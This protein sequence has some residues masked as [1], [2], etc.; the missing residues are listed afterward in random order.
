MQLVQLTLYEVFGYAFP[1]AAGA[2]GI[3]LLYWRFFLP[4]DQDWT[5]LSSGGWVVI[6]AVAY[7]FGHFLQAVSNIFLRKRAWRPEYRTFYNNSHLPEVFRPVL[8]KKACQAI[9]LKSEERL[10]PEVIYDITDHEVLQRAKTEARDIYVYREGFYR[11][12]TLGLLFLGVGSFFRT[13]G[14]RA[15]LAVFGAHLALAPSALL[16]TGTIALAMAVFSFF[17]YVRFA[18]YRVKYAFYTFLIRGGD[19]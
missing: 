12:M 7:V 13:G 2:A 16:W 11:G 5:G 17:R 14:P 15:S 8:T 18:R 19:K 9:G 10:E 6:I 3:Y 4:A 1:G